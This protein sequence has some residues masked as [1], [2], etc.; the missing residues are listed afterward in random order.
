MPHG[1]SPCSDIGLG[2]GKSVI[3]LNVDGT[4]YLTGFPE[5]WDD[6]CHVKAPSTMPDTEQVLPKFSPIRML[7]CVLDAQ[8]D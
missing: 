7:S 8:G 2:H 6:I 4:M 1:S 5:G 3:T